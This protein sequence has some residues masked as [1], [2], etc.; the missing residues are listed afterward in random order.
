MEP[1]RSLAL[2]R[3]LHD[4]TGFRS[5]EPELD[6]WLAERAAGAAAR[7]ARTF[8]WCRPGTDVVVAY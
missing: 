6:T 2:D 3:A 4:L 8:G 5:S 1:V 7:R